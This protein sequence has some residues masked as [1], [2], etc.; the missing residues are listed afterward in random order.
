MWLGPDTQVRALPYLGCV[1]YYVRLGTPRL[2]TQT[3]N[4]PSV[5]GLIVCHQTIVHRQL[6]PLHQ[7]NN[8]FFLNL[9]FILLN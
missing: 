2:T 5:Q 4:P 3:I 1:R 8:P 6:I 9:E 7:T